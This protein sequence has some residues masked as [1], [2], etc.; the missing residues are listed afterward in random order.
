ML[1]GFSL[2]S[3]LVLVDYTGQ[4]FPDGKAA[5]SAELM[6][7]LERIMSRQSL[8]VK[9]METFDRGPGGVRRPAPNRSWI[10]E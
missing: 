6:R 8:T 10:D 4:L 7:I 2:G 5:I 3:Y 9:R 1:E